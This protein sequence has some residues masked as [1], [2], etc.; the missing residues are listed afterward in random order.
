MHLILSS[1]LLRIMCGPKC[2]CIGYLVLVAVLVIKLQLC[3]QEI[4]ILASLRAYDG[5]CYSDVI[6]H[7]KVHDHVLIKVYNE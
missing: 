3:H 4:V 6:Y 1:T 7:N 5:R 2:S